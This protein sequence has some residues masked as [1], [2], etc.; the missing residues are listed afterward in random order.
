MTQSNVPSSSARSASAPVHTAVTAT[1]PLS[2]RLAIAESWVTS[3]S[4]TQ[5]VAR[6]AI[7]E[8]EQVVERRRQRFFRRRL[9]QVRERTRV[10]RALPLLLAG[11]DVH[12]NRL[13]RRIAS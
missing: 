10:E 6:A 3:S 13:R 2:I 12:R 7:G 5:H 4:M 9:L 8:A 11:D 1:S